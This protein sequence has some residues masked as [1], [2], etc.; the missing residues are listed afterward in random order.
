MF[1]I[2]DIT[3]RDIDILRKA[4][5]KFDLS[6]DPY[7]HTIKTAEFRTLTEKEQAEELINTI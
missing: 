7:D 3:R 1:I 2:E 6:Q 4:G 5:I